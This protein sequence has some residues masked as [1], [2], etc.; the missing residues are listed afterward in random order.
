VVRCD[1]GGRRVTT[2]SS[3]SVRFFFSS[4]RRH[5]RFSRDWSSDVCS[6]D[7]SGGAVLE[8]LKRSLFRP[9]YHIRNYALRLSCVMFRAAYKRRISNNGDSFRLKP[10]CS[11]AVCLAFGWSS[12]R[13]T[14][15]EPFQTPL[16]HSKLRAS[17]VLR[18]V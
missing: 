8:I 11:I 6:S 5:T 13:D 14:K 1:A 4:R 10:T 15:K 9:L 7:L 18:N 16:S 3:I 17:F 2:A 12:I